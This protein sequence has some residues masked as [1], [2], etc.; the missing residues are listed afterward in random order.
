MRCPYRAFYGGRVWL[1][2]SFGNRVSHMEVP[3]M[4]FWGMMAWKWFV[5]EGD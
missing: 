4:R 1:A 3:L 5:E 2:L